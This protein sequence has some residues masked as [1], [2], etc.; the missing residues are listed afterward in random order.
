MCPCRKKTKGTLSYIRSNVA[1]K[2]R[3]MILLLYWVLAKPH[4]ECSAQFWAL[5]YKRDM[6]TQVHIQCRAAKMV[7][8]L[9]QMSYKEEGE[10]DMK[11]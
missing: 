1:R 3:E 4:L 11:A 2:S 6:N 8:S 10:R 9:K 7:K 5:Q